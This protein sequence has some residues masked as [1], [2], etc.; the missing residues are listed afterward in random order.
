[1]KFFSRKKKAKNQECEMINLIDIDDKSF[2]N[3]FGVKQKD[4]VNQLEE[5][6]DELTVHFKKCDRKTKYDRIII[7]IIEEGNLKLLPVKEDI[8]QVRTIYLNKRMNL[9][10]IT[11]DAK[12]IFGNYYYCSNFWK[13]LTDIIPIRFTQSKF[14]KIKLYNNFDNTIVFVFNKINFDISINKIH[15]EIKIW[16]T[17]ENNLNEYRMEDYSLLVNIILFSLRSAY[18]SYIDYKSIVIKN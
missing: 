17:I 5:N 9:S 8:Q 3:Y 7:A 10:D 1:M 11:E 15:E 14:K 6:M 4:I 12:I 2:T 13:Y 16:A 18:K